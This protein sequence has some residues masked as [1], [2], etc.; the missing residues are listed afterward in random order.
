[1][2]TSNPA[3]CFYVIDVCQLTPRRGT[4]TGGIDESSVVLLELGPKAS[5]S[6]VRQIL[7]PWQSSP[8]VNEAV[9]LNLDQARLVL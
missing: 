3:R 6:R 9:R 4:A 7:T 1:M 5:E 2:R 8:I